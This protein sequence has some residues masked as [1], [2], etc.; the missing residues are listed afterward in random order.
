[1]EFL[2]GLVIFVPSCRRDKE[3]KK[4][5]AKT[6]RRKGGTKGIHAAHRDC[7]SHLFFVLPLRLCV[8]VASLSLLV[9]CCSA[10]GL[11]SGG[12]ARG[13]RHVDT[14]DQQPQAERQLADDGRQE[15]DQGEE[16]GVGCVDVRQQEAGEA[17]DQV[18]GAGEDEQ[19]AQDA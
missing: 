4:R 13:R 10:G 12:G 19:E 5:A 7:Y 16:V 3:G 9:L 8:F 6:R 17:V 1:R 18:A 11:E 15:D 2:I 14:L